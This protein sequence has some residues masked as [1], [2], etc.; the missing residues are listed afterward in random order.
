M[1]ELPALQLLDHLIEHACSAPA[2]HEDIDGVPF[3]VAIGERPL[4]AAI[5]RYR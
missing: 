5:G 4:L 1:H 2:Q 3:A